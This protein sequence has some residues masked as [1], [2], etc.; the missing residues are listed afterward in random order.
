MPWLHVSPG[1][2]HPRY[3]FCG[4]KRSL[5]YIRKDYNYL[6]KL[7]LQKWLKMQIHFYISW[8]NSAWPN[9]III[10]WASSPLQKVPHHCHG[11]FHKSFVNYP[12]PQGTYM[13]SVFCAYRAILKH[14]S[15]NTYQMCPQITYKMLCA[16]LTA[17][18][19]SQLSYLCDKCSRCI[20]I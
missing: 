4:I 10:T 11:V 3:C 6:H 8:I 1:H 16:E 2:Q 7:S 15:V 19:L 9:L 13:D 12:G 17:T 20:V 14:A 18:E 5:S